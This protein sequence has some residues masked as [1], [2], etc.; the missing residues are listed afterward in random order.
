MTAPMII[1]RPEDR[2]PGFKAGDLVAYWHY[3]VDRTTMRRLGYA[4]EP[5]DRDGNYR[6]RG[7]VEIFDPATSLP[8]IDHH[9]IAEKG[10]L[11]IRI[12]DSGG[13]P[14]NHY[15]RVHHLP[16]LHETKWGR[17]CLGEPE[18]QRWFPLGVD[19]NK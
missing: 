16:P 12:L 19:P 15:E 14:I 3:P 18:L 13:K 4:L 7:V 10:E 5:L 8:N 2:T 11:I 9:V 17:R 1:R 6:F